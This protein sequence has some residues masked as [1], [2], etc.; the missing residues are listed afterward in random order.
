MAIYIYAGLTKASSMKAMW[1]SIRLWW[2]AIVQDQSES[3]PFPLTGDEW[4]LIQ[5]HE[6]GRLLLRKH[7]LLKM[8]Q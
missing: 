6:A 2:Q 4:D 1:K 5:Q 8:P 7:L 3:V